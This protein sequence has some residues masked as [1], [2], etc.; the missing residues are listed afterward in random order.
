[1]TTALLTITD[2]E[3]IGNKMFDGTRWGAKMAD[4]TGLSVATV[5]NIRRGITPISFKTESRIKAAYSKFKN[6]NGVAHDFKD[7]D[8]SFGLQLVVKDLITN[9]FVA[10]HNV[11]PKKFFPEFVPATVAE[12]T[13]TNITNINTVSKTVSAKPV[14]EVVDD[15]NLTDEEILTR[16][17]TRIDV[18]EGVTEGVINGYI[19][20]M[21]V[22]GAPGIGKSH[23]IMKALDEAKRNT[24]DMYVDI[25]KGSVRATGLLQTLFKA[26]HGGIVVLDDSDSIFN[27]EESLNL[28]KAAL[29]SSETRVITWRKQSA[30]LAALAEE[31]GV[32]VAEVKTFDFNG[33]V[34]FITNINLKA[35]SLNNEKMSEHFAAL[36]SRSY[37]IDLTMDSPRAK[38]LR[39]HDVFV[40]KG[41]AANMGI[42]MEDATMITD[43]IYENRFSLDEVSLRMA[44]LISNMFM[45]NPD[46]W[47]SII[48]ITKMS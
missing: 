27:D 40:N 19:P 37:F 29:D 9:K 36:I 10:V 2:F 45:S 43:F 22:Y 35:R 20:S 26:R 30:W 11:D 32:S 1:M 46:N 31:E 17:D 13:V 48:E 21:I 15:E 14:Q 33:S 24:P 5:S 6:P 18:M 44:K 3:N 16:I 41:M 25:I 28:L 7:G 39:V 12:Q 34:I 47:K 38:S 4:A 8:A 42:S 23:S